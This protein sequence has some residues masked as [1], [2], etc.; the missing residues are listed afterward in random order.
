[1]LLVK[2]LLHPKDYETFFEI[3]KEFKAQKITTPSV[4]QRVSALFNHPAPGA[5]IQYF[6]ARRLRIVEFSSPGDTDRRL[7]RRRRRRRRPTDPDGGGRRG[8]PARCASSK[9][10]SFL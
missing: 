7:G 4:V 6:P 3:M 5:R 9:A 1:M 10:T 2:E 8:R